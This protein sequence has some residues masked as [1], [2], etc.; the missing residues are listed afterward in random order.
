MIKAIIFDIGGVVTCTDF[1]AIYTNFANRVGI[2]P[3]FVS[4]YSINN[5]NDMILGNISPKQFFEDMKNAGAKPSLDLQ[6]IWIEEALKVRKVNTKLLDIIA[7]LKK[8][9]I[10]GVLSNLSST[11][12]I[13]D[14]ALHLYDH[15]NFVILSCKEHIKKPDP[16][17]Y[18][19]ALK[20]AGIN[21]DEAIF[22]DDNE[23]NTIAA[24]NLGLIDILYTNNQQLLIDL[25]KLGV[26][27]KN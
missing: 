1:P 6:A 18:E 7:K 24:K 11:R 17:F 22:I 13:L 15:F 14:E 16:Q 4:R 21:P 26:E 19:L 23:R 2:S 10:V 5:W 20:K 27:I 9:Y 25:E 8:Q 3:E 12:L